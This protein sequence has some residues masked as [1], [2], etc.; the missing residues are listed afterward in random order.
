[1]PAMYVKDDL[2]DEIQKLTVERI[3]A[4]KKP[5]KEGEI[6]DEIIRMGLKQYKKKHKNKP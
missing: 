2:C 6:L 3:I 1:M 5:I 4:E